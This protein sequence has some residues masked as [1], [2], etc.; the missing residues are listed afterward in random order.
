MTPTKQKS[1]FISHSSRDNDM[2]LR[3]WE[4][5][6]AVLG[7]ETVW[8]D[9]FDLDGGDE[10]VSIIS[11]AIQTAGWFILLASESSM[12]SRWV[13]YEA[14]LATFLSI[15]RANYH[16]LTIKLDNCKFPRELDVVL[17]SRK[18]VDASTDLEHALNEVA[19]LLRKDEGLR[20]RQGDVFVDRGSEFDRIELAIS[21]DKIVHIIGVQGIGKVAL[22]K[23][24]ARRYQ[25]KMLQ[26]DLRIGHDLGLL[27][28]QI[29]AGVGKKQPPNSVE[30]SDLLFEAVQSLREWNSEGG[31]L[32]LNSAQNVMTD[33]GAYRPFMRVFLD[34]CIAAR[35]DFPI[36]VTS[37]R[38][39]DLLPEE[40]LYSTPLRISGLSNEFMIHAIRQWYS[41]MQVDK[42]SPT[43]S[44]L[45]DL[46][47]KLGGYPLAAKLVAGYLAC[48]ESPT[49]IVGRHFFSKF[50]LQI[51]E[52]V[53]NAISSLLLEL[54][55]IIL[56]TLAI[57]DAK[58]TTQSLYKIEQIAKHG[59][60][61]VQVS[62]SKCSSLMLITQDAETLTLHPFISSYFIDQS[63]KRGTYSQIASQLADIAWKEARHVM[64]KLD[65]IP[66]EN[67]TADN[68]DFIT[69]SRRLLRV[70][71]PAHRLLLA[72]G[73]QQKARNLP[74]EMR[75]HLRE[76]V[77]VLYQQA[78]NYSACVEFA[79]KWLEF[80]P[81]DT[82]IALYRAR[83]YR[84][85]QSYEKAT[86][87]LDGLER[88]NDPRLRAKVARERGLIA[89]LQG[90]L[91]QAIQNFRQGCQLR[92]SDG[93]PYYSDVFV[94]L[95]HALVAYAS[96]K[97]DGDPQTRK[98]F[99]EAA[100][101]FEQ[102]RDYVPRF[103]Q[104]NFDQYIDA[105]LRA[106]RISEEDAIK[107]LESQLEFQLD[108]SR[109]Y[110]RLAEILK[111]HSDRLDDALT[112]ARKAVELGSRPA[113][114]TMAYIQT[115]SG[116][117]QQAL[118]TL[119]KYIPETD[120]EIVVAD[121]HRAKAMAS[122]PAQA[123]NLLEKHAHIDDSFVAYTRVQIEIGAMEKSLAE[124]NYSDALICL[125]AAE[126]LALEGKQRFPNRQPFE[127]KLAQVHDLREKLNQLT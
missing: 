87:I 61:E 108:N 10:L 73:Q 34:R 100:D 31:M 57:Y 106:G 104:E 125:N 84:R 56:H 42:P 46:V 110:F 49:S 63:R 30:D 86:R 77:F 32:L 45:T 114:L 91:A 92:R 95:A 25:R 97:W 11:E 90:D 53:V 8:V 98:L 16:V 18:Y 78:R 40:I 20:L 41:L 99:S 117:C 12:N 118:Q 103:D 79:E 24:V 48:G 55:Q 37:V 21:R 17:R 113:L 93:K 119:A 43:D 64:S 62:L 120:Q 50:Q 68:Q 116:Q 75:G 121:V 51:G 122:D 58:I 14:R 72:T 81:N 112:Y 9:F 1:I 71:E 124:Q 123:R 127:M 4:K 7:E 85:L 44:Q 5:I 69:A 15:E 107:E 28:R 2:A 96:H 82:E 38:R 74:W 101:L 54:D 23:A 36:F 52:F 13:Q 67:K 26:I 111:T 88:E 126:R 6:S 3:L 47:E 102:V 35:L 89:M 115:D 80:E 109:L 76:M 19:E 22:V 59:L 83:A 94:D 66:T 39:S 65:E 105:L 60:S 29:I 27:T 33:D 70:A